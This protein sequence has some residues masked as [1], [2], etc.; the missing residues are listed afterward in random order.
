M[1]QY[2]IIMENCGD[3]PARMMTQLKV[4]FDH[5][6]VQYLAKRLQKTHHTL[7]QDIR[8]NSNAMNLIANRNSIDDLTDLQLIELLVESKVKHLYGSSIKP[9]SDIY[10]DPSQDEGDH[11]R[12]LSATDE[13]GPTDRRLAEVD[14][15][16]WYSSSCLAETD[17]RYD[18]TSSNAIA[19]QSPAWEKFEGFYEA[20]ATTYGPD[21]RVLE[22]SFLDEGAISLSPDQTPYS[23]APYKMFINITLS[24]SRLYEQMISIYPPPSEAFCNQFVPEGKQN[25]L[26]GGECGWSGTSGFY[27][28]FG[29]SSF[30]K[31][32]SVNMLP[33]GSTMFGTKLDRESYV[34]LPAGESN[35]LSSYLEGDML[36]QYASACLDAE[37]GQLSTTVDYYYTATP[38]G[39]EY[40]IVGSTRIFATRIASSAQFLDALDAA[41]N[42][43]NVPA[44]QRPLEG[45]CLSGHCPEE[46]DW[47]EYDPECS[48]SPYVEPE[49]SVLAG[50][51]TGIVLAIVLFVF[52]ALFA[53]HRHQMA[54]KEAKVRTQFASRIAERITVTGKSRPLSPAE[55]A[56]EFHKID[57]DK[58]GSLQKEELWGFLESGSVGSM[59]RTDFELLFS[60]I[61]MDRSGSVDFNEFVSFF[62]KCDKDRL[63]SDGFLGSMSS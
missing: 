60:V 19:D 35:H 61:D 63:K 47:C 11:R 21:G 52:F 8:S 29:T 9:L 6:M 17:I 30:E 49:A 42:E 15:G 7:P 38:E 45:G 18:A 12:M 23:Q 20:A 56:A 50:P 41:Y 51:V 62:A 28:R 53:L 48:V 4:D 40:R 46:S 10:N 58:G 27:E 36:T 1:K 37:C 5:E 16:Q 43:Y 54:Q 44:D 26:P 59:S 57:E 3:F 2:D 13:D 33:Y 24:G 39:E 34:S 55:L 25:V 31:D 14:C 32:G 22:P